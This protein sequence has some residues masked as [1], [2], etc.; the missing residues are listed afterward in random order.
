MSSDRGAFGLSLGL[1]YA[2]LFVVGSI[3]IVYATYTLTGGFA[4]QAGSADRAAEARRV[5][6]VYAR[7]GLRTLTQR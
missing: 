5:R 6:G 7:G 3:A 4:R 2:T 1:W